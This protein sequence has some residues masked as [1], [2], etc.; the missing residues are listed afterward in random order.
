MISA[1]F[2]DV[3]SLEIL[4]ITAMISPHEFY[5]PAEIIGNMIS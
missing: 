3:K 2:I 4:K 5:Y 1:F